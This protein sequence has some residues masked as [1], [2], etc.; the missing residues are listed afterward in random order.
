MQSVRG[1][2]RPAGRLVYADSMTPKQPAASSGASRRRR[3]GRP[4]SARLWA[5]AAALA[6]ALAPASSAASASS[7]ALPLKP[8]SSL[9][10]L[11][12]APAPGPLGPEQVPIPTKA[13]LLAPPASKATLRK[14][15]DGIKC[16][17]TEKV[18]F[19]I[20]AHLTVFVAGKARLVPF[21]IG[22]GPPLG[23]QNTPVGP[24]V[25]N[26]TCFSWLHTHVSDGVI[27]VESPIRRTYTLGNFFDVWGQPLSSSRV[28]PARGRV[29]AFYNGKVWTGDPRRIPLL[30]H[31]QIQLDVGKPLV[32]PESIS[33]RAPL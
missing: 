25:T 11:Q 30:K 10:H 13:V 22:I 12:P 2:E 5:A 29:V 3:T 26:G 9:G 4:G 1:P 27:H 19:H 32:A 17:R 21:G 23:G 6:L 16:Q 33:F 18:L 28:G 7:V 8:L 31:A 14:S 24:F 20:H 15:V